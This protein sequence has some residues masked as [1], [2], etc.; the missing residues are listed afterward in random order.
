MEGGVNS[1]IDLMKVK[2]RI[3]PTR[4]YISESK[5]LILFCILRDSLT[6]LF[7]TNTSSF[8]LTKTQL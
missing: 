8:V 3:I 1:P 7:N 6:K 4:E 2:V 5:K